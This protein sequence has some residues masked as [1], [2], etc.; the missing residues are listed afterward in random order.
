MK[1]LAT[2][3]AMLV[4]TL[5]ACT[6]QES[7][8]RHGVPPMTTE[9][10]EVYSAYEGASQSD[11]SR[12]S[13]SQ[14]LADEEQKVY[15]SYVVIN[16]AMIQ[17]DRAAMERYFDKNLTFTHMSGKKQ[18]REEFIGEI[19]DGTLNYFKVDTK[20][21]SINVNGDTAHMKVTHTLTAKVYGISDSWTMSGENT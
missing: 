8:Q 17:K 21:Y 6:G 12:V 13:A 5:A 19:M 4:L 2:I 3:F 10:K 1:K 15:E 7:K 9:E 11:A 20:D 16:T 18:T 14:K